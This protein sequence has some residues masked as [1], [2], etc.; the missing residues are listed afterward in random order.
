MPIEE[1]VDDYY[2][3]IFNAAL[4]V[5]LPGYDGRSNTAFFYK[6][7]LN[8]FLDE[9]MKKY[10]V[11]SKDIVSERC[12]QKVSHGKPPCQSFEVGG[13]FGVAFT[14]LP[15]IIFGIKKSIK[16]A[17]PQLL[18]D[19]N[20]IIYVGM[21]PYNASDEEIG[22]FGRIINKELSSIS[23]INALV[24]TGRLSDDTSV[25]HISNVI[26]NKKS[27]TKLPRNFAVIPLRD[28]FVVNK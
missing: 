25:W 14:S 17:Y 28:K 9:Q 7:I 21:P 2:F 22:E 10:P 1:K 20:G 16:K 6:H 19:G 26:M 27:I 5:K 8:P 18:K 3:K 4:A 12:Y 24:L 15:A 11:S 13:Y 23:R